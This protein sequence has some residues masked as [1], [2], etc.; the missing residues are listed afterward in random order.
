MKKSGSAL[1]QL[2][3]RWAINQLSK[4]LDVFQ[5][6]FINSLH[7][8]CIIA[9]EYK[10]YEPL[11]EVIEVAYEIESSGFS[12]SAEK[13]ISFACKQLGLEYIN[14]RFQ[15]S[16]QAH[17]DFYKKDIQQLDINKFWAEISIDDTRLDLTI[18]NNCSSI[19]EETFSKEELE[20]MY[21]KSLA[22][23]EQ[24]LNDCCVCYVNLLLGSCYISVNTN[25]FDALDSAIDVATQMY[26]Y[27]F[28]I[29]LKKTIA[30][31]CRT[32]KLSYVENK[33]FKQQ[34]INIVVDNAFMEWFDINDV[35]EEISDFQDIRETV[36]LTKKEPKRPISLTEKEL[37][38]GLKLLSKELEGYGKQGVPQDPSYNKYKIRMKRK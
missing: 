36:K 16:H 19:K 5:F 6:N 23:L 34:G 29:S 8:A 24:Q 26:N 27:G 12:L 38:G 32:F 3:Y 37:V 31:V 17:Y 10:K 33:F 28:C 4:E 22:E 18:N 25:N 2:E 35:W 21:K 13:T 11:E 20:Y 7:N 14:N 15:K 1:K 30:F 9:E